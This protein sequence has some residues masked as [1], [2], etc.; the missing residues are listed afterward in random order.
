VTRWLLAAWRAQ[1]AGTKQLTSTQ[2]A[3]A[4]G[5]ESRF[6]GSI[7]SPQYSH[8]TMKLPSWLSSTDDGASPLVE[9]LN[10]LI[11]TQHQTNVLLERLIAQGASTGKQTPRP[12]DASTS[13]SRRTTLGARGRQAPPRKRPK[14][15][16]QRSPVLH[17]EI[18]AV[19]REAGHPLPANVIADRIRER[20]SYTPPRSSKPLSGSNVNSRVANPTYRSRF[21]RR[22]DDLAYHAGGTVVGRLSGASRAAFGDRCISCHEVR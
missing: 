10:L 14:P 18:E 6:I 21:V 17:Q 3:V 22:D 9:R 13:G 16:T 1:R 5:T 11:E 20:G 4:A 7:A 19:L 15:K 12:A 8:P 2:D